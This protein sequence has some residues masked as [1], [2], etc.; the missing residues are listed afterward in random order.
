MIEAVPSFDYR[1]VTVLLGM[2]KI[3][4][5]YARLDATL[6][7]AERHGGASDPDAEGAMHASASFRKPGASYAGDR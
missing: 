3:S 4:P 1:A 7:A 5:G 6:P 2:N